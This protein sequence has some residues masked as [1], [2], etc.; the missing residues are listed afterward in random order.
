GKPEY[1]SR[2]K[3]KLSFY[4][5]YESLTKTDIGFQGEK[6]GEIKTVE[7]LPKIKKGKKYSNPRI[8]YD[9][10]NWFL[11]V[12]YEIKQKKVPLTKVNLGIDVGI[13]DLAICSDGAV[14]KNINKTKEVRRL[15]KKLRREQRKLSRKLLAN[16]ESYTSKRKPIYKK[17]L[18][19]MKNIQKQNKKIRSL[20]K[21]LSDIR[22]NYIH[23]T[24]T[25][26]V[27]TKPSKIVVE[28][29]NIKG[30]IKNRHLSKAI[31]EQKLY[32]VVRQLKY[33]C[34]MYFINFVVADRWFPS[35]KICSKCGNKKVDLKLT[36]RIYKCECCGLVIDRDLNASINLSN[37]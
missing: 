4:V 21:K 37:Y 16:T 13:K 8:S 6:I 27:R 5:N 31:I 24:T 7:P 20:Y 28:H 17:S 11:S 25:R 22:N 3:S 19:D 9:G 2:H 34:E 33:K 10:K 26:I 1:K 30:M 12:G 23:Q 35:S 14:Y 15:K 32:E 36:D 18:K 29:L